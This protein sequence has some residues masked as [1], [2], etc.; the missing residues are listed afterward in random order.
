MQIGVLP[1]Q[2]LCSVFV[3][4]SSNSDSCNHIR[5]R[6]SHYRLSLA[7]SMS[8]MNQQGSVVLAG[9]SQISPSK[10]FVCISVGHW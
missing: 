9:A 4:A 1:S 8:Y 10:V 3:N 6:N 7:M 2:N 5:I